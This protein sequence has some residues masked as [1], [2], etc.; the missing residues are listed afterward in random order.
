MKRSRIN[1]WSCSRFA[2]WVRGEKKPGA[3]EWD[4]WEEWRKDV[5]SKRPV[6]Y[7]LAE[8]ALDKIQNFVMFPWDF[9]ESVS[10]WW[11]NRFV[12]KTHFLKTGLRPGSFHELDDRI[13]NGLFNEFQEF[14]EV[15]L[16]HMQSYGEGRRYRFKK[17]RCPEAGVDYLVWASGLTHGEDGFVR[18]GDPKYGKPTPQAEAS[19]KMLEIYRW[20][21]EVRP[22][23][24]DPSDASGWSGAWESDD[25]KEKRAASIRMYKMEK[26][27]DREDERM[28]VSLVR[29]RKNLWT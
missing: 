18:K 8:E 20:W 4:A 27:H 5:S 14:V 3:L 21:T 15:D 17:G 19:A 28:L 12:A 9:A 25:E 22:N 29:I 6:R 2:D 1:Y 23:R 26:E 7:F 13:L 16:A 10:A 24:P 11:H